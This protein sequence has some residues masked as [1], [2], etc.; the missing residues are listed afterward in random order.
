MN[1][2]L[3]NLLGSPVIIPTIPVQALTQDSS[4]GF[5]FASLVPVTLGN[6]M[7]TTN[8]NILNAMRIVANGFGAAVIR[9][10]GANNPLPVGPLYTVKYQS[11][12]GIGP[13]TL[14]TPSA[15][16]NNGVYGGAASF[17]DPVAQ[18]VAGPNLSP[19]TAD[20]S[21]I[22][23]GAQPGH[24]TS[25]FD[26]GPNA[27]A[28]QSNIQNYIGYAVNDIPD[29]DLIIRIEEALR[30][31]RAQSTRS[32]NGDALLDC[33]IRLNLGSSSGTVQYVEALQALL[34]QATGYWEKRYLNPKTSL[35]KL[36]LN[37]FT[38]DG[39]PIPLERMLQPRAVSEFLQIFV[40]INEFLDFNFSVNPFSLNFLFNPANPQ[41]IGRVKRYLSIIFKV[42][43]YEGTPPGNEPTAYTQMPSSNQT[44]Y[45]DLRNFQ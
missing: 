2:D 22:G 41:L 3:D 40:R 19:A 11:A 6:I 38:Y 5:N 24:L 45:S 43:T 13:S 33:P 18:G 9:A 44:M 23:T 42:H 8:P 39:F 37:F 4:F 1:G 35:F 29:N 15:W 26:L 14:G 17:N 10:E 34:A 16:V 36:H 27:G 7:Q 31:E 20:A 21:S 28:F 32:F 30:D 12:G 25:Y